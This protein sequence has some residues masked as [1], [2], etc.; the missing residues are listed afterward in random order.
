MWPFLPMQ[1]LK[2][3]DPGGAAPP[4]PP[5]FPLQWEKRMHMRLPCEGLL[6]ELPKPVGLV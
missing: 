1:A 5:I 3:G 4:T 6:A 2:T